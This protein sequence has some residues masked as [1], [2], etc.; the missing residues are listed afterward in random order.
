MRLESRQYAHGDIC[1]G[2][3][4]LDSEDHLKLVDFG[5]ADKYG[6]DLEERTPPYAYWH[7]EE[8]GD[9]DDSLGIMGPASEEFEVYGNK[10]FDEEHL[11][12]M[13]ERLQQRKFPA[14]DQ[15][16]TSSIIH[17]CWHGSF[18]TIQ[19]LFATVMALEEGRSKL[20]GLCR[21]QRSANGSEY[22]AG[23]PGRPT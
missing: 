2:N 21:W 3:L 15:S 5:S 17:R 9:D 19:Q 22:A 8:V 1:S 18:D 16:E 13:V 10:W 14:L 23:Q 4:L 20:Q 7:S 11:A 6:S 12:E